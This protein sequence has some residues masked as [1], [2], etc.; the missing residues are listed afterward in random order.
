M[1]VE[2]VVTVDGDEDYAG[3]IYNKTFYVK[4]SKN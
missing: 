3:Q 1:S 4:P 2:T